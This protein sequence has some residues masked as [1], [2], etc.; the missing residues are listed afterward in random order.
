MQAGT[1]ERIR[2]YN[3]LARNAPALNYVTCT[4][5]QRSLANPARLEHDLRR[6]MAITPE[7][8]TPPCAWN[9]TR[10]RM[11]CG[12]ECAAPCRRWP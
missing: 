10:S 2:V 5:M 1:P 4:A 11:H 9:T 12:R 8:G 6:D 7:S 3:W